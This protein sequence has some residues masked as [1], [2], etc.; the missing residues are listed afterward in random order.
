MVRADM[1]VLL[2]FLAPLKD[3]IIGIAWFVPL[4][5]NT[6]VWRGNRYIIGRD[7]HLSACPES[8]VFSWRYRLLD[9]IR[10]RLA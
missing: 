1:N 5:S 3:L 6:V 7:S 2:F 10:T 4:F 8:G 9:T